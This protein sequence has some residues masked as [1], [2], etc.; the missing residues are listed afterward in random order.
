MSDLYP[1]GPLDVPCELT[2]P[3][4]TYK[5]RAWLAMASLALFVTL[6]VFLAGW[7]LLTSYRTLHEA[8]AG[9]EEGVG[10]FFIGLCSAFLALF[11]LKALFFIKRGGNPDAVEISASDQPDL[12]QFL[13]H[14]ADEAGAPKPKRVYLSAQVN[15]AVFYD[16]SIFNLVFPSRKNLEIGLA[17]VNV[18]TLS[19]FKAVLAHEF[20]HFAQR[21]M[22]IGSWVYIA[23]QIA[24]HII[25]KRDALDRL[26]QG[27]SR[28]DLR[29]AWFGWLLSLIVWSIRS[30]MDS[31]LSLVVLAQ[32]SLSRQMEFQADLVAVS[33][34]GS[35]EIVHALHKLQ[36]ADEAWDRTLAFAKGEVDEGR[37]PHDLFAVQKR[38]IEKIS[39]ILNDAKYGQSPVVES[40]NQQTQRIFKTSIAQPPQMW[41][42]HPSNA[43]REENTK[44][45]YVAAPHDDR[46]AWLLFDNADSVKDKVVA[47]LFGDFSAKRISAEQTFEAVDANYSCSQFEPRFQGVYLGRALFRHTVDV[48]ELYDEHYATDDL[49]H[50]LN[51]LYSSDLASDMSLLRDLEEEKANLQ[52]LKDKIF[53][54]S[55]KGIVH[56][57]KE[58]S[59]RDLPTVIKQ[60]EVDEAEVRNRVLAHDRRCR[61]I[62]LLAAKQLG[63]GNKEYLVGLIKL[64]HYA[65]HSLADLRDAHGVLCNVVAVVTADGKVSSRELKRLIAAA[66]MLHEVISCIY[67]QKEEVLLDKNL[68]AR[69]KVSSWAEGLE[70]YKLPLACNENINEWMQV[71][72]GWVDSFAG[73][74][75]SLVS[76]SLEQLL[77]VEDEVARNFGDKTRPS[78][79]PVPSCVPEEYSTLPVGQERKRQMRLGFWDRFQIA[80]GLLPAFARLLVAGSIVGTVLGFG[81]VVGKTTPLSIYNGFGLSVY[82][83]AGNNKVV[84]PP[85]AAKHLDIPK[86]ASL[87]IEARTAEGKLIEKFSKP[88]QQHSRHYVYNIASAS[89][90]VEWTACYGD[91]HERPPSFL[92]APRWSISAAEVVFAEPPSSVKI[93]GGGAT[94]TVLVGVGDEEPASI[95]RFLRTEPE[96]QKMVAVHV[97]WEP[98]TSKCLVEWHLLVKE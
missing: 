16:L 81:T 27:I 90:L 80:D 30:L 78:D 29:I 72:D 60:V 26:I 15:A 66:N 50:A 93:S 84:L 31:L 75:S 40:K 51:S 24:T 48:H 2:K 18:L 68:C 21:S 43:D 86:G 97:E 34:T 17:L 65:E 73:A 94:R 67:D 59:R 22:A 70:E 69:L 91:A 54:A 1:P 92:G 57:G 82:V 47:K 33:L 4:S 85:Y 23:Q 71:I 3:K 61:S 96:R 56:R 36:A 55:G 6:Y 53:Q 28:I 25:A 79:K 35:D 38:I 5:H 76:T 39:Y 62:H 49:K 14:L 52:A 10:L 88:I 37:L 8:M 64:L 9:S 44:R 63:A 77:D 45:D 98:P 11:M 58:I 42:T 41:S 87:Q 46:T 20:G 7:F 19:E 89:P 74:L 95:L 12:F 13:Q 32:R 83:S